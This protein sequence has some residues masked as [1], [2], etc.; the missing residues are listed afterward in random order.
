M[1]NMYISYEASSVIG[2]MPN[3]GVTVVEWQYNGY[4]ATR[5]AVGC[6]GFYV[7]AGVFLTHVRS[8]L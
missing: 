3:T 6:A 7:Q 4:I 5:P 1:E 2:T 8:L